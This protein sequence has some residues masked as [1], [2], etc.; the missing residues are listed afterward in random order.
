MAR[1]PWWVKIAD[2]GIT[3]RVEGSTFLRTIGLGTEG[4]M[5]PEVRWPYTGDAYG[6]NDIGNS[7]PAY[8]FAVDIWSVGEIAVRMMTKKATFSDSSRLWRYATGKESFPDRDLCSRG[9]SPTCLS[10]LHQSMD[11]VPSN[12][13]TANEARLHAWLQ[14][15]PFEDSDEHNA[16][17]EYDLTAQT[18]PIIIFNANK[19]PS[20]FSPGHR[21]CA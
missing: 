21:G 4:F 3:K 6:S 17:N 20:A 12:R 8:S 16:I 13:C 9:I 18:P 11:I 1:H 14:M 7:R 15:Q 2:F 10:F 19:V 5:A